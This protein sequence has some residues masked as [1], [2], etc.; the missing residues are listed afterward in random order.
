MKGK[1]CFLCGKEH[2]ERGDLIKEYFSVDN[3]F[4]TSSGY[5][6]YC[7]ECYGDSIRYVDGR[8]FFIYKDYKTSEYHTLMF[9]DSSDCFRTVR[10]KG[11]FDKILRGDYNKV[12]NEMGWY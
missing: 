10:G 1:K 8:E 12:I 5:N 7:E 6:Y 3:G 2:K 9:K 11:H 4:C